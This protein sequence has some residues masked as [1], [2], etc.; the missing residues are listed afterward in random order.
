MKRTDNYLAPPGCCAACRTPST[1]SPIVDMELYDPNIVNRQSRIY[2]CGVCIRQAMDLISASM[3]L[4][5]VPASHA[6]TTVQLREALA[7]TE[8]LLEA[9]EARIRTMREALAQR[10]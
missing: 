10:L 9:S 7:Y 2:L 8:E 6:E 5:I 4:A 3:N 1:A